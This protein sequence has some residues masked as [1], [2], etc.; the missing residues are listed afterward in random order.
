M[1]IAINVLDF[2]EARATELKNMTIA[3][4]AKPAEGGKRVFQQLPR[5]MRRR[6]MS[7]NIRR[8][9]RRLQEKAAREV[10]VVCGCGYK[11]EE[12]DGPFCVTSCADGFIH[13]CVLF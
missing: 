5:H 13:V 12:F 6:A 2:A 3:L 4:E 1:P 11:G 10:S 8:L 7:H 9:P